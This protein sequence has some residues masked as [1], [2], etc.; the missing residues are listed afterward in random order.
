MTRDNCHP[1]LIRGAQLTEKTS[2]WTL[3][4]HPHTVAGSRRGIEVRIYH[5]PAEG[6]DPYLVA[7]V[8]SKEGWVMDSTYA[9]TAAAAESEAQELLDHLTQRQPR[10]FTPADIDRM[11]EHKDRVER[12]TRTLLAAIEAAGAT[13][14][15]AKHAL[16]RTLGAFIGSHAQND[17]DRDA[18]VSLASR[19]IAGCAK[20]AAL[21][22]RHGR[23]LRPNK[24]RLN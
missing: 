6:W 20:D 9:S 21:A 23:E 18:A 4:K 24:S 12:L 5:Y 17:A 2:I 15:Q 16:T 14:P 3:K 22:A 7:L 10:T 1:L 11:A 8:S 19:A 13:P